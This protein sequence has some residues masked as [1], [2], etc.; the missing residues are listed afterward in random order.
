MDAL[1]WRSLGEIDALVAR[2][3]TAVLFRF[4]GDWETDGG[5]C[6]AFPRRLGGVAV[7]AFS[8]LSGFEQIDV[9]RVSEVVSAS[10]PPFMAAGQLRGRHNMV[11]T[12][13]G[14]SASLG[15]TG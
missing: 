11:E 15:H 13:D 4:E 5:G 12:G 14:S 9:S 8:D 10:Q 2:S 1:V 3:S 6:L 7:C